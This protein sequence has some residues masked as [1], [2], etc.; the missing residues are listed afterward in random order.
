MCKSDDVLHRSCSHGRHETV[1]HASLWCHCEWCAHC[2]GH[3]AV[4][5]QANMHCCCVNEPN[6]LCKYARS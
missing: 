5:S 3:C 1:A 4:V 2:I 6:F